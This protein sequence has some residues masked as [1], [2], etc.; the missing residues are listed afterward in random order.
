MQ[1]NFAFY[2][3]G[4][5]HFPFNCSN[6]TFHESSTKGRDWKTSRALC[7]NSAEGDLVSI[8]EEKERIFLKEIIKDLKTIK[9]YIGLKKDQGEWRWLSNG[10]SVPASIGKRPWSPGEPNGVSGTNCATIYG[11]YKKHLEGLFDDL[12]C[13]DRR[14]VAGY[15]CERAVSCTKEGKGMGLGVREQVLRKESLFEDVEQAFSAYLFK[16]IGSS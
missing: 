2:F 1:V 13:S 11:N 3:T 14:E 7:Q 8:E 4:I 10:N 6:Y 15:I 16:S 12:S 5:T 9:Y